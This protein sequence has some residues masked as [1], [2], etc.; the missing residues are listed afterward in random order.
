MSSRGAPAAAPLVQTPIQLA[1]HSHAKDAHDTLLCSTRTSSTARSHVALGDVVRMRSSG[2]RRRRGLVAS[3]EQGVAIVLM[4]VQTQTPVHTYTLAPSDRVCTPP[5][6]VERGAGDAQTRTTLVGYARGAHTALCARTERLDARGRAVPGAATE[7]RTWDVRGAVEGLFALPTGE[8][9]AV[10]PDAVVLLADPLED[11]AAELAEAPGAFSMR[12]DT[13]LV[14]GAEARAVSD[15]PSALVLVTG[16]AHGVEAACIG[17]HADAPRLRAVHGAVHAARPADV[18]SA[19]WTHGTLAV[20]ERRGALV[21]AHTR[22]AHGAV[23]ASDTR[24]VELAPLRGA[25]A[26]LVF[27]SASHLLLLALP[28][29]DERRE[30]AAAL[31]WDV[32]LDTVLAQAEWS[33]GASPAH[34]AS[35]AAARVSDAHVALLVDTPHRD[36][37]RSSVLALPVSVPPTGLL[38]H[39][40]HAAAPTAA[41]R[42]AAAAPARAPALGEAHDAL[43]ARAAQ[44]PPAERAATLD[45]LFA[46]FVREE[47]ERLRAAANV[48]ASRKA[49]KPALPTP[50]VQALLALALPA[51]ERGQPP[52]HAPHTLRY[53]LERGVVSAAMVPDDAL[54]PRLR[55]TRDWSVLA[56]VLRHVPDLA[57]AHAIAIV[58]DALAARHDAAAPGVAR[59]LQHV[60]A[61]PP[62]SKPAVRMALRTH[63]ADNDEVLILLD[64]VRVWLDAQLHAPLA[65]AREARGADGV[66]TVPRTAITYRTSDVRAPPLDA[67]ASFG[68]DVL[69]TYFPQLLA[70]PA[71]HACLAE[72]TRALTQA[73]ADVQTLARLGAPLDAFARA[74]KGRGAARPDAKS[75]RLALHE[76]SLLV[77]LYSRDTLDV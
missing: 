3:V 44:A 58:R 39:A 42:G 31:V 66:R 75:R 23:H 37:V 50:F 2:V 36:V 48:K 74:D 45:A 26:R 71:T 27:L 47:S 16:G 77:P 30:R 15:A 1:V 8:L 32:E 65:G 61:P 63:I 12:Y 68:E 10:R 17:V 35:V 13:Q 41:W 69:D 20:L 55:A 4:D 5:L 24:A 21:S 38:V 11:G 19:A 60:L 18:A 73:A 54:V 51:P 6:V 25:A 59:V 29:S 67:V 49:P 28:T 52:R 57:E 9:L 7:T 33:L 43:L 46:A 70:D 34:G 40:L 56:L 14:H 62:F 53:L 64:V 22:V 76:A 72:V